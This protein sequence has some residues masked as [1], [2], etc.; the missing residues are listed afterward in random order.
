MAKHCTFCSTRVA[1]RYAVHS[2]GPLG[3]R[4]FA[5]TAAVL[6]KPGAEGDR[7][8]SAALRAVG[9]ADLPGCLIARVN[10]ACATGTARGV[11][12]SKMKTAHPL[13]SCPNSCC[14]RGP[15]LPRTRRCRRTSRT[16]WPPMAPPRRSQCCACAPGWRG[17]A[18]AVSTRV[19]RNMKDAAHGSSRCRYSGAGRAALHQWQMS[20]GVQGEQFLSRRAKFLDNL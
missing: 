10:S 13:R 3:D 4:L 12:A 8:G 11:F 5:Q 19:Q 17:T 1:F 6:S 16:C 7:P 9:T 2:A 18:G 15:V 14:S 20:R